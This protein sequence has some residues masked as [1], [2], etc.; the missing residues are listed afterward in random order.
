MMK[1]KPK[2]KKQYNEGNKDN[3]HRMEEGNLWKM[4]VMFTPLDGW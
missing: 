3:E 1:T 4:R 2:K